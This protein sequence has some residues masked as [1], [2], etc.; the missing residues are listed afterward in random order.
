MLKVP[1]N[2]TDVRADIQKPTSVC[3]QAGLLNTTPL[4][5]NSLTNGGKPQAI[6]NMNYKQTGF[7]WSGTK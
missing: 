1:V 3:M 7:P 5:W 2:I 6:Q 4:L